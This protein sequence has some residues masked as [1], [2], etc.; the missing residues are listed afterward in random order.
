MAWTPKATG[1]TCPR[2]APCGKP[3]SVLAIIGGSGLSQLGNLK[4]KE[5]KPARTPYGE[6]SGELVLGAIGGTRVLF[7]ARHGEGHTIAAHE[8]NY[9]ANLW[10]L[11]EAGASEVVAVATVG[12][13]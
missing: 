3:E 6:P 2:S 4:V 11:K 1:A 10:A 8:V 5:R 12:A 7:L 13:I 9:R